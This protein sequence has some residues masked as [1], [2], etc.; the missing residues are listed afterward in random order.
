MAAGRRAASRSLSGALE[1]AGNHE[2]LEK[3]RQVIAAARDA[4]LERA[5]IDLDLARQ[6]ADALFEFQSAEAHSLYEQALRDAQDDVLATLN[7]RID[8]AEARA[9]G[10]GA[11]GGRGRAA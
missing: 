6:A 9:K 3:R 4:R 7:E 5:R 10:V 8:E 2:L 1:R 11:C